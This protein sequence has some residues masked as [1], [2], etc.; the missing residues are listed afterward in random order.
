MRRLTRKA[1]DEFGNMYRVPLNMRSM[2]NLNILKLLN[3]TRRFGE[4]DLPELLCNTKIIPDYIALY[5]QKNLYHCT[6]LTCVAFYEY[7]YKFDGPNGLFNAIYYNNTK[8]LEEYKERFKNV[9][10]FI[11]PDY[12]VFGDV[13]KLINLIQIWK[14]RIV[15]LWFTI[16][17][18]AVV[19]PNITYS[20]EKCFSEYFAGLENCSVV[21]FSTKGHIRSKNERNLTKAAVKYV[22]D[23][24]PLKVIIVYSVC[25]NDEKTYNLFRYAREKGVSVVIPNNLLR[26]RNKELKNG[27]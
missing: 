2:L 21:A 24:F 10:I 14:A 19:I 16:E 27:K 3:K 20:S 6:P 23:H 7:D 15:A 22:V 9:R 25:G 12:S 5:S 13:N 26:T 1:V 18:S 4:Y 8:L 11:A 17:L